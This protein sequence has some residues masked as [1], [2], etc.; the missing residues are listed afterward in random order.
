M[1]VSPSYGSVAMAVSAGAP[2]ATRL[3]PLPVH[4]LM[5]GVG[6]IEVIAGLI[7]AFAPRVGAWIVAIWLC[8]IVANLLTM[9][10]YLDI[11]V[12]DFGLSLGAVALARLSV[13]YA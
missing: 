11:A 8:L 7:V 9:S 10:G 3:S 2:L 6:V 5:L 1:T 13:E 4:T 12:R